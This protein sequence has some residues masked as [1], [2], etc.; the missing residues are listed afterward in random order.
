MNSESSKG[1]ALLSFLAANVALRRRRVVS[2]RA[3]DRVMW[4]GDLP[5]ERPECR[6]PFL[7]DNPDETDAASDF[8]LQVDKKREPMR[9]P[10]PDS[11]ADWASTEDVDQIDTEPEL[12]A[13]ITVPDAQHALD[14]GDGPAPAQLL[15]LVDHP[16]VQDVWLSYLLDEW[17][18]WTERM[19]RWQEVQDVYDG[20]DYMRRRVEESE[21][22]YELLLAVGLL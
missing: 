8:W 2:Y 22:R 19:R 14:L 18:P 13:E 4:L 3:S 12:R 16:E 20:L 7:S 9:S 15:R 10:V 17:Q 6:S 1:T 21:E 11:V 5:R